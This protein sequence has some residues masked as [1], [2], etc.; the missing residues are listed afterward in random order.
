MLRATL[1]LAALI[2]A[3]AVQATASVVHDYTE[4][5]FYVGA[6][7][8]QSNLNVTS[9]AVEGSGSKDETGFKFTGGYKLNPFLALEASYYNPGTFSET[10]GADRLRITADIFQLSAVG[11]YPLAGR[12][13]VFGR[14]AAARWDSK[15][16]ATV[17]GQSGSLSGNGTDFNWGVGMQFHLNEHIRLRGEFEQMTFDQDIGFL[18]VTWRLRFIQLAAIYQF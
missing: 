11:S 3:P 15:L 13:D 5:G 14:I 10:D 1:I 17:S 2:A 12:L 4:T 18:P 7:V 9:T 6:A 16:S 8:G